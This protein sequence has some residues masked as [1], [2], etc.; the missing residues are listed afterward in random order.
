MGNNRRVSLHQIGG[1]SN[2]QQAIQMSAKLQ[3]REELN[4][5]KINS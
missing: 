5:R 1:T 3:N 2:Q 4:Y